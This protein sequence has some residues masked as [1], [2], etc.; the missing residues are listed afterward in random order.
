[1]ACVSK[2]P[3]NTKPGCIHLPVAWRANARRRFGEPETP[4]RAL[5]QKDV[6]QW[7]GRV[8]ADGVVLSG[9][10]I[11]GPGE[12]LAD[13]AVVLET[14][15]AVHALY[16]ELALSLTTN[17]LCAPE[18]D[19]AVLAGELAA[20]GLSKVTVLVDAIDPVVVEQVYAWIRPGRRTVP[21]PQASTMLVD[22]QASA[23]RAFREAGLFVTARMTVYAGI[24]DAHVE[25][26]ASVM[27]ALGA[28]MLA[29]AAYEPG[30]APTAAS[31]SAAAPASG[32][33]PSA[34]A[35][36]GTASTCASKGSSKDPAPEAETAEAEPLPGLT[37]GLLDELRA[38]AARYIALIPAGDSCGDDI[39]WIEHA[40]A[41]AVLGECGVALPT[42]SGE[43]VNVAVASSDG[44]DV[45]LHLG[46]AIKFLIFG[47]RAQDGLPSLLGVRE[48]PEPG[49]GD[50]RW[51]DLAATLNDCFALLAASAGAHP[52]EVLAGKGISVLTAETDI[53]GAVDLLFGGGKKNGKKR[54]KA[55]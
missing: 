13:P 55:N 1:M 27:S 51:T 38:R 48:A 37:P 6:L 21:L 14:L 15:A 17:G 32:C 11:S 5:G 23:I 8:L 43:R 36:C 49:G 19:I 25:D 12:P 9:V 7:L 47:P 42:P 34:C 31:A 35:S 44:M 3:K 41:S 24:N 54:V 50:K 52:R 16:P 28:D 29:L 33:A 18:A 39:L 40:G 26:V 30:K 45:D 2:S 4:G 10:G 20:A 53:K 22:A 46:Q